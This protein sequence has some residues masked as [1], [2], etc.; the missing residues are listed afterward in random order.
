MVP[1]S[2]LIRTENVLGPVLLNRYNLFRSATVTAVPAP[3]YSTGDVINV[4]EAE[5][6]TALPPGFAFEWTGTAQQQLAKLT[7]VSSRQVVQSA[8]APNGGSS[9]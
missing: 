1:L 7:D 2:T 4:L 3:G 6:A 8:V 5:A 9:D